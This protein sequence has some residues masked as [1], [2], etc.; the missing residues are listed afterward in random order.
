MFKIIANAILL[1]KINYHLIIWPFINKQNIKKTNKIII[2]VAKIIYGKDY[3]GKTDENILK[4]IKWYKIQDYHEMEICKFTQK[5]LNNNENYFLKD[6]LTNKWERRTFEKKK[7]NGPFK[8]K[9]GIKT[10]EQES[11]IYKASIIYNKLPKEITSLKKTINFK[12]CIK[13]FYNKDNIKFKNNYYIF[14][15][16]KTEYKI[17]YHNKIECQIE[18][19]YVKKN[20]KFIKTSKSTHYINYEG[21]IFVKAHIH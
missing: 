7:K 14:S 12:T 2:D 10:N 20:V 15:E 21:N 16:K 1:G 6:L 3:Y 8:D 18:F 5:I 11:Y 4:T 17:D 9:F 13:K 19:G